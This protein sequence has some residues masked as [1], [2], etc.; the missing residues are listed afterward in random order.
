MENK[1]TINPP[2]PTT[3]GFRN[4]AF[5]TCVH[6]DPLGLIFAF[7]ITRS[8][9]LVE[10][11]LQIAPFLQNKANFKMGNISIS[12]AI[13]KAYAKEQRTMNNG[14]YSKQTQSNPI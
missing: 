5:C 2:I 13:T 9:T 10:T 1:A 8:S 3:S 7:S 4:F 12:T 11:P 14:P 6:P